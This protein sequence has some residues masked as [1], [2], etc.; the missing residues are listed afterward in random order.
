MSCSVSTSMYNADYVP[1][2][3]SEPVI[4]TDPNQNTLQGTT[5]T[6]S[7][8]YCRSGYEANVAYMFSENYSP[9]GL[10]DYPYRAGVYVQYTFTNAVRLLSKITFRAYIDNTRTDSTTYS[11]W[12]SYNGT[13]FTCIESNIVLQT[14]FSS[15]FEGNYSEA[16]VKAIRV[17]IDGSG[18]TDDDSYIVDVR[19][20]G[21]P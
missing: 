9:R 2:V 8:N 15:Q 3:N 16:N 5:G 6:I 7:Y 19:L 14:R 13:D 18:K 21:T 12:V 20:Y 4:L 17:Q 1:D 10:S 11:I